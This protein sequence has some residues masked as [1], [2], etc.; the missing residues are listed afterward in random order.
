MRRYLNTLFVQTEGAWLR[1]DGANLVVEANGAE[2]GRVPIHLLGGVVCVGRV[3]VSSPLLGFC[4]ESGV[5]VTHLTEHGRFLARVEG[6]VSGNVLLRREQYRRAADP[7]ATARL[8]AAVVT[9]KTLNQRTVIRRA[10]RDHAGTMPTA[11]VAALEAAERRLTDIARRAGRNQGTDE[12][13]GLE[14]EAGAVYFAVFDHLI[15]SDD[16]ALRFCGRSRRPPL[17]PV[18][19][20]LSLLY[21][22]LTH[23][24]R[25]ALETFGLD[26]A[27]GFLHRDHPGRPS[28]A[29]DL[30][31]E[32]RPVIADRLAL[33]LIN[34]RQ[35][36]PGDWRRLETGA[37]LPT[38]DARKALLVAFQE[39]K[40]EE[41]LHPYLE[42]R[43][44]LGLMPQLQAQLLARHLR[45]DLDG[46][47][48][49][50]WK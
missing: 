14:G 40:K 45:G 37:V 49:F 3:G 21:T 27:V 50:V 46:Y 36:G 39:R 1:K 29:L 5:T 17:D 16:P 31:E 48:P 10:L 13:R 30:V 8:V 18:N 22:L 38:D 6:P 41:M 24:C 42:E 25:S 32:F 2:K 47:P 20:L 19:A 12:L 43:A 4:C 35:V 26:P 11:A 44:P 15:R 23:D 28:L 33:S 9:A 7:A 34:R